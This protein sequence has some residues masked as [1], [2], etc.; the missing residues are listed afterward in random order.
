M[1][2]LGD[3]K[4]MKPQWLVGTSFLGY[5]ATLTVG[6]GVPIPLLN[7][8]ILKY[9]TVTDADI[10]TQ[11]IDYS[12]DYPNNISN[13]LAEVAYAELKSGEITVRGKKVPTASVSS[14]FKAREIAEE[15]KSWIT[16][17][18]FEL[19]EP[20]QLLPGPDEMPAFKPLIE[21]PLGEGA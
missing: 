7:E 14:Y 13:P 10:V 15:L 11:V 4:Q 2:V 6:L 19:G 5:G 16:A 3:L 17:G 9:V 8:E 21:R 18:K 1:S 12:H 20:V